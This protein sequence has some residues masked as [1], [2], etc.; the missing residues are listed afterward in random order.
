M[1]R[2]ST[3]GRLLSTH[4]MTKTPEYRSWLNMRCRCCNSK[5]KSYPRYGGRGITV[6]ERWRNSFETFYAD[7]GPKPGLKYTLGR[8]NNSGNYTPKN[9]RWETP[10]EQAN[11]R[12]NNIFITAAGKTQSIAAWA[13]TIG[14]SVAALQMRLNR[15][16]I[17]EALELVPKSR[18]NTHDHTITIEGVSLHLAEWTRRRGL[19]YC[20][21]RSRINIMHWSPEE[22]LEIVP[23]SHRP[24]L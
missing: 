20:T 1:K 11:N 13:E 16:T 6:C 8:I 4:G 18:A 24:S 9:C 22:A 17:D 7:L 15:W 23:R 5:H 19:N 21:V 10:K 3:S 2:D 12:C 14:L